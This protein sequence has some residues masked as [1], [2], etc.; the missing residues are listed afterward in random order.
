MKRI[1]HI[2]ALTALVAVF[3]LGGFAGFLFA[4]GRLNAERV[5]QIAKVLRGE[6]P[7]AVAAAPTSQP[8]SQPA[9]PTMQPSRSEIA[10]MQAQK[11]YYELAGERLRAEAEQRRTLNQRIQ[12]DITRQAEETEARR[13]ET[14]KAKPRPAASPTP[15][16]SEAAA[17]ELEVFSTMDPKLARDL[18]MKRKEPDAVQ[19]FLQLEPNRVKKIVDACKTEEERTWIGRILSQL[20]NMD[21]DRADGVDGPTAPSR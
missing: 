12:L 15:S 7:K 20:H 11:E 3:A 10:R 17:K 19:L 5:D 4:T 8:T 14:E 2:L 6:F 1:Y 13:Q 16:Q 18:L 9:A 21:S